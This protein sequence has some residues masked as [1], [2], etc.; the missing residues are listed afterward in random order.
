LCPPPPP[1]VPVPTPLPNTVMATDLQ[2]GTPTV[3]IEGTPAGAQ[4]SFFMKSTGN[5]V[6]IPTGGGVM[7]FT[8]IGKAYWG[9]YAMNVF[10]E[11]Q[12][13][14]RHM[15]LLTH[16]HM[17]MM[18]GNTPPAPWLSTMNPPPIPPMVLEKKGKDADAITVEFVTKKPGTK[19]ADKKRVWL[20]LFGNDIEMKLP[21]RT[22]KSPFLAGGKVVFTGIPKGNCTIKVITKELGRI[23]GLDDPP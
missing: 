15:D 23:K 9:S 7:T 11:G 13:A 19:D 10:F 22:E 3:T 17:A 12:P 18:P 2:G 5:E 14:V 6:A 21:D 1:G 16:N 4:R 20:P 8:A